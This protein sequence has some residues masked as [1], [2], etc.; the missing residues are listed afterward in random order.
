MSVLPYKTA[1]PVLLE[2]HSSV[3]A[4]AWLM[5][6]KCKSLTKHVK[7]SPH[8]TPDGSEP[9]PQQVFVIFEKI[10]GTNKNQDLGAHIFP[11]SEAPNPPKVNVH[12]IG[13]T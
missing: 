5:Q 13:S 2:A 11:K 6:K 10:N 4:Q 3:Q 9:W 7:E 1:A 8:D 12:G